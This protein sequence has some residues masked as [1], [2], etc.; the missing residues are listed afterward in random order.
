M[1]DL[2]L[3]ASSWYKP[4]AKVGFLL[5]LMLAA[6]TI[7]ASTAYSEIDVYVFDH[8]DEFGYNIVGLSILMTTL[9]AVTALF[10]PIFRWKALRCVSLELRSEIFQYRTRTAAYGDWKA[11]A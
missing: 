2:C 7:I 11:D 8:E 10:N 4:M 9:A 1:V 5:T 6:A 3:F